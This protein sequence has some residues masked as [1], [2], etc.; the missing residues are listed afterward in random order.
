[1]SLLDWGPAARAGAIARVAAATSIQRAN[2]FNFMRILGN[3]GR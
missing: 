1:M 3:S 2:D